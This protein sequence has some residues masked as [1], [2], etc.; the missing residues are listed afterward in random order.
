MYT[1]MKISP[2][3]RQQIHHLHK[4]PYDICQVSLLPQSLNSDPRQALMNFQ[5][6]SIT[7]IGFIRMESYKII[8]CCLANFSF[9]FKIHSSPCVSIK[10]LI[11]L[12]IAGEYSI[13]WIYHH[14]HICLSFCGWIFWFPFSKQCCE[15]QPCAQFCVG[16]C[17]HPGRVYL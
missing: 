2:Q 6:S 8:L 10:Y 4:F 17:F 12:Y 7:C 13:L 14:L 3:L 11:F 9:N 1:P 5:S 16:I 15:E